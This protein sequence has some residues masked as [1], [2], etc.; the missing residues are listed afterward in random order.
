MLAVPQLLPPLLLLA[1]AASEGA[2]AGPSILIEAHCDNAL[3]LRISPPGTPVLK[4]QLGA[5]SEACAGQPSRSDGGVLALD[6]F[7][8]LS[9]GNIEA[10]AS[11]SAG[12]TVT[13]V[14]DGVKL[15]SG[16]LPSFTAAT[17]CGDG[18]YTIRANYSVDIPAS[19]GGVQGNK[20]YGLGQ[21][22]AADSRGM[23]N[24][25]DNSSHASYH[26]DTVSACVVPL[27]RSAVGPVA[28][29]SV[30]YWI[31]IPWI[32]NRHS[33]GVFLNQP[34]EGM[35]DVSQPGNLAIEFACQ[36]QLDL[37][38]TAAPDP[39]AI[40]AAAV[41]YS[42]YAH[43]TGLPSPLPQNAALYW[44]SRN[45]YH[46]TSEVLALAQNFSDK[47]LSVGVIVID[48][49]VPADPPYYRL[50]PVRFPD[51]PSMA[52]KVKQLTGAD[53]MPNL[54]PTSLSS[55]DCPACGSGHATDGHASDGN[56]DA[57][58]AACRE[59][60][61]AK[62]VAPG[63]YDKGVTAFWLDDDERD[64]FKFNAAKCAPT[65]PIGAACSSSA[66]CKSGLC[67]PSIEKCAKKHHHH[68]Q[69]SAVAAGLAVNCSAEIGVDVGGLPRVGVGQVLGTTQASCCS[70]C[71]AVP[72]CR[73]WIFVPENDTDTETHTAVSS[74]DSA[75]ASSPLSASRALHTAGTCWLLSGASE[76]KHHPNRISGG[77]LTPHGPGPSPAPGPPADAGGHYACGPGAY[78]GM[79]MAGNL[80]PRT[81]ADGILQKGAEPLILSRNGWAGA[82]AHGVALWSSDIDCSWK[83]FRA[84][85][86][87]GMSSGLSGIPFWSS[88]VGGF[89]GL[90][91]PELASRWH[92]FGSVCP[93]YRTHG[94]RPTN[95][96]WSF[97]P[98][99]EKS[100]T[101]SIHLRTSLQGYVLALAANASKHGVREPVC[102]PC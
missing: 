60:I 86:I 97:G 47:N 5:L 46:N 1:A 45:A 54:K 19:S 15:L 50:D 24:C 11:P 61:W 44:Q 53:L 31:A 65:E 79:A 72:G 56:V 37:W 9:N 21:L 74:S 33:W 80:W 35:T 89:G 26:G 69:H 58:S 36:K 14:S 81:Y 92:Q 41:V 98:Q 13:R 78:C 43:A 25:K 8:T 95:E 17:A 99:A 38:V 66:C 48:L 87:V 90:T 71:S 18:F 75:A 57:S 10:T 94:S 84:Q 73:T 62:R 68:Q 64:H 102:H 49:G 85:V 70:N 59:C 67:D 83:E 101:K 82:A 91:T 20:W 42:S 40:D 6:G 32:Y 16:P 7:G 88:D 30:K 4:D 12:L 51:V 2:P 3:R 23:R 29:T 52:K 77:D 34:G 96:P 22:G 55:A 63:L 100:I 93:L 28:I 27:E 39:A 76:M